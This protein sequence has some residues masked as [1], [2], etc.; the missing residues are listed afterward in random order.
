VPYFLPLGVFSGLSVAI[1]N[2]GALV[3]GMVLM[4]VAL[5]SGGAG[6]AAAT[7][8]FFIVYKAIEGNALSPA[9][10]RRTVNVNPLA[11][12]LAALF[13]TELGGIPGAF[14]AVPLLGALQI[15]LRELLAVR[16]DQCG[17]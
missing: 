2:V 7:V 3:S 6:K 13:M 15:I 5:L 14:M 9:V 16:R 4:V 17:K 10:F 1:P 11:S 8:V 12:L